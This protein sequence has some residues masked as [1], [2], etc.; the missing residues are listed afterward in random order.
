MNRPSES[1]APAEDDEKSAANRPEVGKQAKAIPHANTV[2]VFDV[3]AVS[4]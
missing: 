2:K 4:L 1:Q 3:R